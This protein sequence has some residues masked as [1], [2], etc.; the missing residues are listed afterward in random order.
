MDKKITYSASSDRHSEHKHL[1][2]T[3]GSSDFILNMSVEGTRKLCGIYSM[4]AMLMVAVSAVP[5][6]ISKLFAEEN[7]LLLLDDKLGGKLVFLVMT[8]LVAAGFIGLLI[9]MICCVKKEIVLGRNK[10]LL[11]FAGVF[12]SAVVSTLAADDLGTAFFGY[13][14]R[15]EGL[16]TLVGYIGFFAIGMSITSEK[17][18][19]YAANTMVGIGFVNSVMAI[20]Q[21]IPALR[22]IIP[23]YYNF[24]FID[25][26]SVMLEQNYKLSSSEF[27][28]SYAGY[29]ASYAADGFCC[30]PFALGA[31]LTVAC[32]FAISN[33][34]YA[35][36]VKGRVIN[37]GAFAFMSGAAVLTQTFP[38]MLGIACVSVMAVIISVAKHA[39]A[40]KSD[41]G[42]SNRLKP[43][44][45]AAACLLIAGG[46]FAGIFIS[47]NFRLRN[48]RIMYT[49]AVERLNVVAFA[50]SPKTEGIYPTLWYEGWL[51]MQDN[52]LIGVGPDNWGTM[53][54][55]GEGME[56]DRSYNEYLDAGITRGIIGAG[57]YI[58]IIAVT[59]VKAVRILKRA[60][61]SNIK[62]VCGLFM[63][64]TAYA[65]QAFFNISTAS[66]TPFFYL[67]IGLIWSYEAKG[68]SNVKKTD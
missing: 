2:G 8:L 45:S 16:I 18:R 9:F 61:E 57:L 43:L 38:A 33:A 21:S 23:S 13:L 31:L 46:V 62:T 22:K 35:K 37:I 64:F 30:S 3:G 14:D 58:A 1:F 15:A 67:V 51:C 41:E 10:A 27:M 44:V 56:L 48:E 29:D 53:N 20:L 65:V 19:R 11:L 47:G 4:I 49:D 12:L 54:N 42:K 26:R 52:L 34:A 60:D 59:L 17:Y 28:G 55:G 25:Y 5:Y 40:K 66:S 68:K 32:A 63:A 50:H 36:S 24:L 6:Y 39:Q 7:D